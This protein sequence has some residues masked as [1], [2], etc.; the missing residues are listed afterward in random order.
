MTMTLK[1]A[2]FFGVLEAGMGKLLPPPTE[3]ER[4]TALL[5]RCETVLEAVVYERYDGKESPIKRAEDL[6]TELRARAG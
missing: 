4:L 6:L 3:A 5:E 1:L 2:I